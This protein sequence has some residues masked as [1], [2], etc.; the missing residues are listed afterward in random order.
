MKFTNLK[1]ESE[2]KN[3]SQVGKIKIPR[4]WK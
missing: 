4:K 3:E 1:S 2:S